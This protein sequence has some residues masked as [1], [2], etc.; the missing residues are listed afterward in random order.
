[1]KKTLI[2]L[3]ICAAFILM[4][5][6]TAFPTPTLEDYDGT[7]VGAFGRIYKDEN[8]TWVNQAYGYLYGIYKQGNFKIV[9]G[10]ITNLEQEQIGTIAFIS[11][12]HIL[13]GRIKNMDGAKAPIIG[14]LFQNDQ[15]HFVGR[16][17]SFFG[18]APHIWGEY[19]PN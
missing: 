2:L 9:Y 1:M 6:I 10:N 5:V 14:F 19:T 16:I 11:K 17:M 3:G 12:N 13:L 4:P 8:G 15:N 18:P 7:F